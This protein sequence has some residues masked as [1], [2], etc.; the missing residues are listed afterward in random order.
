MLEVLAVTSFAI[1]FAAMRVLI[2]R[3]G[4]VALDRPN[5]RSLHEQPVPRTGGLAVV[6]GALVSLAFGAAALGIA[7]GIA[8]CLAVLSFADDLYGLPSSVRL[9]GHLAAAAVLVWYVLTPMQPLGLVLLGVG[10][11][12]IT[13]VYNFMDGADGLA[14]GMSVIGFGAYALAAVSEGDAAVAALS[15]ALAASALAFLVHNFHP[16]RIFL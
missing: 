7:L 12:W 1:A 14:G 11:A 9:I 3:F 10:V 5:P 15:L 6:L 8:L 2:S 13:N 4:R 16:A